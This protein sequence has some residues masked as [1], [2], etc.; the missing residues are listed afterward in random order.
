MGLGNVP[1]LSKGLDATFY[2]QRPKGLQLFSLEKKGL[3]GATEP[4]SRP[5]A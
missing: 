1:T 5:A 3:V 4:R 2:Q